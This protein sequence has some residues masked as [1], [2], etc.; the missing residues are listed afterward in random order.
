MIILIS[1][2]VISIIL[3]YWSYVNIR[4]LN[5]LKRELKELDKEIEAIKKG[6]FL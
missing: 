5:E 6:L 3:L 1:I 4:D 2:Y